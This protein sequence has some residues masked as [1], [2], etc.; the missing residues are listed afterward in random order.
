MRCTIANR[1][2]RWSC[3]DTREHFKVITKRAA[4]VH[5]T[6]FTDS[7]RR[8]F[9]ASARKVLAEL[10]I[11][12]TSL[13]GPSA[14]YGVE[15]MVDHEDT[16]STQPKSC[17]IALRP[18]LLQEKA[19]KMGLIQSGGMN[20]L[21]DKISAKFEFQLNLVLYDILTVKPMPWF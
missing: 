13:E 10:L 15:A 20:K 17:I 12:R 8:A 21:F 2:T 5:V 9:T 18:A 4:N 7:V 1:D 16:A 19:K 3:E 6:S 14:G 11:K